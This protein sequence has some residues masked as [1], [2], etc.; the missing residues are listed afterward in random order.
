[1]IVDLIKR[2]DLLDYNLGGLEPPADA[3][4]SLKELNKN[5]ELV[6]N[7]DD[8]RWEIYL[9]R[10]DT[11]HWQNSSPVLGS[12]ITPGIKTWLQKFD[13]THAGKLDEDDRK[14][15]YGESLRLML[16]NRKRM[17]DA[18][19]EEMAYER[20][21]VIHGLARRFD[22]IKPGFIAVPEACVGI[23]NE[24]K[25]VYAYKKNHV[26]KQTIFKGQI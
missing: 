2:C 16:A 22:N 21:D 6:W 3:A 13:S 15:R 25:K 5:L 10:G 18:R 17:E 4:R 12:T 9:V 11:L 7:G 19:H 14:K 8:H 24:G 26:G 20:R 23:T 1:M